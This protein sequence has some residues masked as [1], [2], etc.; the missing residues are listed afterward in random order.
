MFKNKP[1]TLLITASLI[2]LL[3]AAAGVYPLVFGNMR[4]GGP[5]FINSGTRPQMQGNG[6]FPGDGSMPSGGNPP[7]GFPS[8]GS[9][10]QSGQTSGNRQ[11]TQGG[12]IGSFNGTQFSGSS[13]TI[14]L[15][16]LLQVVQK[17]GAVI[18]IVLGILALLGIFMGKDWGRKVAITT[19]IFGI[20]FSAAGL[21]GFVFGLSLW[22]KIAALVIAAA[23]VVLSSLSKSRIQATVPA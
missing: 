21:F 23:V 20:L 2:L 10:Q 11:F 5:G 19:A 9:G 16:Q 4:S 1:V 12:Q 18:I 8:T 3:I 22:I 14:K 7:S 6:Q 15:L 13:V 17:A